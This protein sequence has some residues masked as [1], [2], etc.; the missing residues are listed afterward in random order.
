MKNYT[1]L[2][3]PHKRLDMKSSITIVRLLNFLLCAVVLLLCSCTSCNKEK[4]N[5]PIGAQ[6]NSFFNYRSYSYWIMEDS[7]TG[8]IDSIQCS[9]VGLH[10]FPESNNYVFEHLHM[11]F[12]FFKPDGTKMDEG[13]QIIIESQADKDFSKLLHGK[14]LGNNW[15]DPYIIVPMQYP[16]M[17]TTDAVYRKSI[18]YIEFIKYINMGVN[19][20]D[21]VYHLVYTFPND[22]RTEEFFLNRKTGFIKIRQNNDNL[23]R[24][25][26]LIRYNVTHQQ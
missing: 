26:N 18:V 24:T 11:D 15:Y 2:A 12:Q 8:E 25:L 17:S 23:S 16:A 7:S 5:K 19:S 6:M 13:I 20:F 9:G 3:M 4:I 22:A 10:T 14:G 21:S 1:K